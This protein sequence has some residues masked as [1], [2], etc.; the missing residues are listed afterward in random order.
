MR[1]AVEVKTT[2]FLDPKAEWNAIGDDIRWLS[3]QLPTFQSYYQDWHND[4]T[5]WKDLQEGSMG[6]FTMH[7]LHSNIAIDL[8]FARKVYKIM[9]KVCL[10]LVKTSKL[11]RDGHFAHHF[12][13]GTIMNLTVDDLYSSRLAMLREL[14]NVK[15]VW[16]NYTIRIIRGVDYA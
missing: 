7:G 10:S 12:E 1:K 4:I 15:R 6:I 8:I 3:S 13:N 9:N 2:V 5:A 14:L 16:W 11:Y